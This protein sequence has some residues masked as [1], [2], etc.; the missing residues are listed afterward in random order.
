MS[1]GKCL[2]YLF[3]FEVMLAKVGFATSI[4]VSMGLHKAK[5]CN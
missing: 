4:Y 5:I 3:I 1:L 2:V